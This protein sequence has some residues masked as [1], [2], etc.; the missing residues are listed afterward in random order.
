MLLALAA[1]SAFD[2]EA[3]PGATNGDT[4]P[5][6]IILLRSDFVDNH[7]M[8]DFLALVEGGVLIVNDEEGVGTRYPLI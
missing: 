6:R 7:G 4:D 5:I 3:N 8:T 1:I 2:R